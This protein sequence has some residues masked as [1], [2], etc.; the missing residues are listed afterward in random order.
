MFRGQTLV[1]D[2]YGAEALHSGIAVHLHK[3][4]LQVKRLGL[5][6]DYVL[7]K[8]SSPS[9]FA[10]H[11][12]LIASDYPVLGK[13]GWANYTSR[14]VR[15]LW[16]SQPIIYHGF[17]N[18]NLPIFTASMR[19]VKCVL[20]VHDLIPLLLSNEVGLANRLQFRMLISSALQRADGIVCVSEWTYNSVV[21]QFPEVASRATVIKNGCDMP[22][23]LA[24]TAKLPERLKILSIS[25]WERYKC[26]E[27]LVDLAVGNRCYDFHLITDS[28]G[29]RKLRSYQRRYG[30]ALDNLCIY[31]DVSDSKKDELFS[32]ASIYLHP[33]KAEGFC[34][35]AI[36]AL[37]YRLPIVY[38]RGSALDETVGNRGVGVAPE[39]SVADWTCG[40]RRADA[41]G[42]TAEFQS[43]V[44]QALGRA[45]TW[46][47]CAVKLLELYTSL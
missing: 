22:K 15:K 12:V 35:P 6:P 33:S 3:V 16:G 23:R 17:A 45:P 20:T 7:L 4:F 27:L 42:R 19:N 21:E 31:V 24:S 47:D 44:D 8:K 29:V 28:V 14:V 25:R 11:S 26:L 34:L 13:L 46:K 18:L 1:W 40:I 2:G 10:G 9:F 5:V 41:H 43:F 32:R 37:S 30:G 39:A 38:R 36:E